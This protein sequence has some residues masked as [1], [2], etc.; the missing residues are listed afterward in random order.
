MNPT[1]TYRVVG[2]R[3]DGSKRILCDKIATEEQA[4][5]ISKSLSAEAPFAEIIIER[6]G[7]PL[8]EPEQSWRMDF[9]W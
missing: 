8:I 9:G 1:T 2:V 4:T 3:S 5:N 6:D 7:D